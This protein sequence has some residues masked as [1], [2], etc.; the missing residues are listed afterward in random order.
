MRKGTVV[1]HR[2]NSL[3]DKSQCKSS[4]EVSEQVGVMLAICGESNSEHEEATYQD[5]DDSN[6]TNTDSP[7]WI[8]DLPNQSNFS[9]S[10]ISGTTSKELQPVPNHSR[11]FGEVDSPYIAN[12]T[13][14]SQLSRNQ[15]I[16]VSNPSFKRIKQLVTH[17][18]K[19]K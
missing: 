11:L 2:S 8:T 7:L 16:R 3:G 9:C 18:F 1:T 6:Q 15:S 13:R 19:W 4:N 10:G 5:R 17:P 12:L 14:S